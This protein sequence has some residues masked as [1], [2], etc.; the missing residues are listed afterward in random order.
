MRRN[1]DLQITS[2]SAVQAKNEVVRRDRAHTVD[3]VGQTTNVVLVVLSSL[4]NYVDIHMWVVL[5]VHTFV[6]IYLYLIIYIK[7]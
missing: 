7:C 6:F 5:K 3:P 1:T 2:Y 4:R